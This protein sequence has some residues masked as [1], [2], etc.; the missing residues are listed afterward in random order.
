MKLMTDGRKAILAGTA[1]VACLGFTLNA[2]AQCTVAN[3]EGGQTALTVDNVGTPA[4]EHRR[5]GGPCSLEVPVEG[6]AA[7]V[8]DNKPL[9]ENAYIARFYAYLGDAGSADTMIFAAQDDGVNAIQIH[10]NDPSAG[11]ITMYVFDSATGQA[12]ATF[13]ASEIDTNWV[14]IEFDWAAGTDDTMFSVNGLTDKAISLDTTGVAIT[15]ALLGNINGADAGT[16]TVFYFDDFDS[17][18]LNRPGRLLV[19]DSNDDQTV[20]VFDIS[21]NIDEIQ[22]DIY[23]SGQPDCNED[24]SINVFDISCQI[25]IIQ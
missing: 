3:W 10:Y 9:D 2:Q 6:A 17:R 5:Y 13:T 8:S 22:S 16:D 18:R 7:Y 24:G 4:N 23:S 19:G 20:N 25:D 14:S 21:A 12:S 11:D 1:L 15:D